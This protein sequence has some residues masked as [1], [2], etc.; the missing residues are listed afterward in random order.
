MSLVLDEFY[1]HLKVVGV[2]AVTGQGIDEFFTA[3]DEAADEYEKEYKPEIERMIRIKMEKEEKERQ[4]Q[5]NRLMKDV[6]V[7]KGAEVSLEKGER[8]LEDETWEE[9]DEEEQDDDDEEDDDDSEDENPLPSASR[10]PPS[11]SQVQNDAKFKSWLQQ[12]NNAQ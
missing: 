8:A 2:S 7:S 12:A 6:E 3:V 4:E 5:L 11:S 10:Y 1:Q 9:D